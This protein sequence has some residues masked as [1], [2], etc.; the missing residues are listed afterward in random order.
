MKLACSRSLLRYSS[1][2][3]ESAVIAP[4]PYAL[5]HRRLGAIALGGAAPFGA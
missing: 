5:L 3:L 4:L 1:H 2:L